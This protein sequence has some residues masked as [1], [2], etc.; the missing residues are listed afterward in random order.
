MATRQYDGTTP[1]LELDHR[2]GYYGR[3][4]WRPPAPVT[5]SV[6][7]YDN[8]G[9]RVAVDRD[10]Q[11]AWETRFTD[12]GLRWEPDAR[13]RVLAQ[14]MTGETLMG[15]PFQG[16]GPIW[17]NVGY[18][19]AYVLVRRQWR[20]DALSARLDGFKTTDRTLKALDDNTEHGWA[21]TAAWR[22]HLIDHLDLITEAQR[23]ESTRAYRQYEGE[24]PHRTETL[25]QT[26]LRVSF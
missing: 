12:V 1:V 9:S 17:I 10:L 20:A 26:A 6:I 15:Y 14:A 13:T 8:A 24:A 23:I 21:L 22:H 4:E 18:K 3:L 16:R 2:A 25:L 5:L 7:Y 19:A 11:W